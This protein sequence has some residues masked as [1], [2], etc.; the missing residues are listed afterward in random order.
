VQA[1]GERLRLTATTYAG[2]TNGEIATLRRDVERSVTGARRALRAARAVDA[3]VGDVPALLARL[4][5]AA[6]AV[7]GELRMLEAQPDR[8]RV[9]AGLAGPR[10][11]AHAVVDSAATL[12]DGLLEAAGYRDEDLAVLQAECA[13]EADAL[14]AASRRPS[15]GLPGVG[16]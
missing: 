1:V 14:R 3:P 10:S 16:R 6:R 2:G 8:S 13:I 7:D 12:V 5:L 4:E 11:R 15:S 9:S